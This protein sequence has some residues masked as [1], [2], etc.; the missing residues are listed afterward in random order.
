M[1][2]MAQYTGLLT[3]NTDGEYASLAEGDQAV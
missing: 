2:E 1:G 3:A